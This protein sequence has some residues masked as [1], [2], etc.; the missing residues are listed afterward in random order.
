MIIPYNS[1]PE[2]RI[3]LETVAREGNRK[4]LCTVNSDV[5]CESTDAAAGDRKCKFFLL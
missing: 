1:G 2:E 5:I 4:N 3:T